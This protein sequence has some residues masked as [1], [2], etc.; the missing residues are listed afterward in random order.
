MLKRKPEVINKVLLLPIDEILPSPHQPRTIFNEKD[1][2]TLA[3]S[4]SQNGLLMPISVR[5]QNNELFLIAGERRLMACRRLGMR[6]IPAIVE[7]RDT[8]SSA[9]LTL[10]EN[11]HR[12]DLNC[13]EEAEGIRQL[14]AEASLSQAQ[15]CN[16]LSMAQSTVA[17]KLRILRLNTAVRELL[18]SYG[19]GE[20]VARAL[21]SLSEDKD[22]LAACRHIAEK[23]LTAAQ[24]ENYI[25]TLLKKHPVRSRPIAGYLRDHRLLFSTLDKA[26]AQIKKAGFEA[27]IHKED[28][29]DYICYTV[30]FPKA[31]ENNLKKASKALPLPTG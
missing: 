19:L 13:F 29:G 8:L 10:I 7:D 11:L 20:R 16:F 18:I 14:M 15:V 27:V 2:D 5:R 26:V 12:K 24:A 31:A 30:R 23:S 6:T 17:N 4:I 9:V 22:Q 28:G 3:K 21:L 1:L 25:A